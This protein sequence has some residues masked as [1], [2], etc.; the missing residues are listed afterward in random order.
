MRLQ[1]L[2]IRFARFDRPRRANI[3]IFFDG[4]GTSG[5][6]EEAWE[7]SFFIGEEEKEEGNW[8]TDTADLLTPGP[9]E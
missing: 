9:A 8:E 4:R 2:V 6:E 7:E 1:S 3:D 5:R